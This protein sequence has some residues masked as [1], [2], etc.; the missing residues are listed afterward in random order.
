LNPGICP[1]TLQDIFSCIPIKFCL[2]FFPPPPI[3]PCLAVPFIYFIYFSF[4][5]YSW[6][7]P[8]FRPENSLFPLEIA[9]FSFQYLAGSGNTCR[10]GK[11]MGCSLLGHSAGRKLNLYTTI[12]LPSYLKGPS[13]SMVIFLVLVS[14][15]NCQFLHS[16]YIGNVNRQAKC[17]KKNASCCSAPF[18]HCSVLPREN[19]SVRG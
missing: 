8:S 19:E 4:S 7:A 6:H 5:F 2:F 9:F 14:R 3:Q 1:A 12:F 15:L 10:S 17:V 16:T 13:H 18:R 11:Q